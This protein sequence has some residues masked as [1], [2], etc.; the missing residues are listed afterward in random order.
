MVDSICADAISYLQNNAAKENAMS[1]IETLRVSDSFKV[2]NRMIFYKD[3]LVEDLS[4]SWFTTSELLDHVG[5]FKIVD[6]E[7]Y[8]N[9]HANSGNLHLITEFIEQTQG[10]SLCPDVLRKWLK[11]YGREQSLDEWHKFEMEVQSSNYPRTVVEADIEEMD[12]DAIMSFVRKHRRNNIPVWHD[13]RV[14]IHR[15]NSGT[16]N[17]YA[18]CDKQQERRWSYRYAAGLIA[19]I[20]EDDLMRMFD[21]PQ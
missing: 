11:S 19:D 20:D 2:K 16:D 5:R 1:M 21:D 9:E 4:N 14:R 13:L 6:F 18:G 15:I 12:D 8:I 10:Q 7:K 3:Q 17:Y